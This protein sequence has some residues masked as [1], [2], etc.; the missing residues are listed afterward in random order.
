MTRQEL[1]HA[2]RAACEIAGD[3]EVW[4]F[5][6]QAIL[7]QYPRAPAE[8]RVSTEADV[9]PVH[10]PERTDAI[11][12][13]I[14]EESDFH[15]THGFWV[16]GFPIRD[17]VLPDGWERRVIDVRNDNTNGKTGRCLEAHDLAAAKLH[18][19]REK[20]RRF[21]RRLLAERLVEPDLLEERVDSLPVDQERRERLRRWVQDTSN[22]LS[23]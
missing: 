12:A 4:V 3:T 10:H 23:A 19:F 18:A 15:R 1:E 5:G 8:L 20:D 14:G 16:H 17:A 7:G 6:S 21:V 22:E 11:Y 9:C 2:I 13:A